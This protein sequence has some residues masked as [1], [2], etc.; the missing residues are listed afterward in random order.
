[1]KTISSMILQLSCSSDMLVSVWK[2]ITY[3]SLNATGRVPAGT[4]AAR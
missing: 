3:L 2:E 1:M 4:E